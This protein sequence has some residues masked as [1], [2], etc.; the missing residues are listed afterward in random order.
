MEVQNTAAGQLTRTALNANQ[1]T[2]FFYPVSAS[3][4][5]INYAAMKG[6]VAPISCNASTCRTVI[7]DLNGTS[8][9]LRLSALYKGGTFTIRAL[10]NGDN[11]IML[12]GVQAQVDVTGKAQDVLRRIQVRFSLIPGIGSDRAEYAIASAS[13]LCKRFEVIRST[14]TF[15]IPGDIVNQDENNPMCKSTSSGPPPPPPPLICPNTVSFDFGLQV[16]T[17]QPYHLTGQPWYDSV[18]GV[19]IAPPKLTYSL[20]ADKVP[21]LVNINAGCR[22]AV[23]IGGY[24]DSH[25]HIP[26]SEQ[27]NERFAAAF[28]DGGISV[29]PRTDMTDDW[30]DAYKVGPKKTTN[31]CFSGTPDEIRF[32]HHNLVTGDYSDTNSVQVLD[33]EMQLIGTCVP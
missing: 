26:P 11:P 25:P 31:I 28:Y 29:A 32:Q 9:S 20:F 1:R 10:D 5:S 27:P 30:P 22:Y 19:I 21:D 4:G 16:G 13:S 24:D 17:W 2:A 33:I 15:R 18:T 6:A 12:D 23:T 14:N 7:T 3:T 8:F